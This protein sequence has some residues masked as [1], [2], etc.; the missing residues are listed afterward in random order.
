MIRMGRIKIFRRIFCLTVPK[1]SAG[2]NPLAFT[3]FGNR[4]R[5][6]KRGGVSRLSVENFGLTVP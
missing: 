6:D 2:G 5:L 3:I 1:I 4:K